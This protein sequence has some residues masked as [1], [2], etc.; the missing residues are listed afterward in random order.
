MF[1]ER[2]GVM[3]ADL[4]AVAVVGVIAGEDV[5]ERADGGFEDIARAA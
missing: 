5:E 1:A 4:P 2:R 3:E